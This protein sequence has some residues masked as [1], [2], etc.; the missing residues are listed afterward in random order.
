MINKLPAIFALDRAHQSSQIGH[1]PLARK[2]G[3]C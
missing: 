2:I 1:G 3:A